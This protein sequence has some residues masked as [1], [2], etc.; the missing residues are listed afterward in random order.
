MLRCLFSILTPAL[1]RLYARHFAVVKE[2]WKS[3]R[4]VDELLD[5]D[6]L[7]GTN[8]STYVHSLVG[9]ASL[10]SLSP[11]NYKLQCFLQAITPTLTRYG[12]CVPVLVQCSLIFGA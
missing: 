1:G 6:Q 3:V 7:N 4:S 10:R 5:D 9:T 11:K 8:V 12:L 2:L